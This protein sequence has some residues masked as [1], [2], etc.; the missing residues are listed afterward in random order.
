MTFKCWVSIERLPSDTGPLP[1]PDWGDQGH[2]MLI[3]A[4]EAEPFV[5][6]GSPYIDFVDL[7]GNVSIQRE[8]LPKDYMTQL[9]ERLKR[10]KLNYV[11][12]NYHGDLNYEQGQEFG[13][14]LKGYADAGYT[15]RSN[16]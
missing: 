8:R 10:L 9:A 2:P 12:Q 5:F 13:R 3:G 16:W 6:N 7:F 4:T 14:Y 11:I 15:L 1:Q